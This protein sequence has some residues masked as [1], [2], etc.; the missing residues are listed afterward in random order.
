M[1]VSS[2]MSAAITRA[3]PSGEGAPRGSSG[4]GPLSGI[5]TFGA[6]IRVEP[7]QKMPPI[8]AGRTCATPTNDTRPIV[9]SAVPPPERR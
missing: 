8:S 2:G 6:P 1:I 7:R 9:A 5:V 3:R 4:F